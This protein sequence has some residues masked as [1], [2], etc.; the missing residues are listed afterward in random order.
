MKKL[1]ITILILY[2]LFGV[3]QLDLD[4]STPEQC[5]M[6][7]FKAFHAQD[8]TA[9]KELVH[10]DV[11]LATIKSSSSDTVLVVDDIGQ[12]YKSIA[13]IPESVKFYEELTEI[14]VLSDVILAHVWTNYTFHLND[15]VSH[16][17]VNAF[18]L[19]NQGG[20]WKIFY[21][22]DTRRKE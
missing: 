2:P 7:F 13:S 11:V 18:T 19:I 12:F 5:I 22:V 1:M 9:L 21:L 15:K 8:T 10:E 3:A 6:S 4:S 20:F 14:E 17:G 16:I